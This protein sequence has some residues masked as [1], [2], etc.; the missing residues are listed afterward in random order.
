M[1]MYDVQSSEIL[2]MFNSDFNELLPEP[3]KSL[4]LYPP[5]LRQQIDETNEWQYDTINNGV[6]KSGF[7]T[8]VP[9]RPLPPLS[10]SPFL[11]LDLLQ[12]P[13][14]SHHTTASPTTN[15]TLI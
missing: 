14:P 10:L 11:P 8:S 13:P 12:W 6:Y 2:R 7:A 1:L 9:S 15:Q 4:D 5:E 3:Y